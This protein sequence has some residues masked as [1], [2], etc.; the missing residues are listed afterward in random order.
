MPQLHTARVQAE[1]SS[2]ALSGPAKAHVKPMPCFGPGKP[3]EVTSCG[4]LCSLCGASRRINPLQGWSGLSVLWVASIGFKRRQSCG[5]SPNH[6][7]FKSM[8]RDCS[9][10]K[11]HCAWTHT[12]SAFGAWSPGQ[13]EQRMMRK[14]LL[15]VAT[16]PEPTFKA[17]SQVMTRAIGMALPQTM[18]P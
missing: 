10:V 8:S 2:Q 12:A 6:S 16:M 18:L 7:G 5:N 17:A 1:S 15:A 4:M 11:R 14:S 13:G 3:A 9:P